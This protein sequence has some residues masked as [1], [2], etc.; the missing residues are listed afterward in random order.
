MNW[1]GRHQREIPNGPP[2]GMVAQTTRTDSGMAIIQLMS[3]DQHA[4]EGSAFESLLPLDG[5]VTHAKPLGY[6]QAQYVGQRRGAIL[7]LQSARRYT[8]NMKKWRLR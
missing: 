5:R 1:T 7:P 2:H 6:F 4:Q 3:P 8:G